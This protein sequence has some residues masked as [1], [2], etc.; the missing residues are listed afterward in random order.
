MTEYESLRKKIK[1]GDVILFSGKSGFSAGIKWMTKSH[2][3]HVGMAIRLPDWDTVLLWESTTLNDI[4]DVESGL[5]KKGVQ[6]V[7]LS[8]RIANYRG[9]VA[10]RHLLDVEFTIAMIASLK[11]LRTEL[12][13]RPYEQDKVELVKSVYEGPWGTNQEDL[14]SLF[15]SELVAEAYQRLGLL[16]LEVPS[17]EYT[18]KDFSKAGRIKLLKGK[19][20]DEV[21]LKNIV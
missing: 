20:G 17:N 14:S 18:P 21:V 16:P 13:N 19:L 3:S 1:T 8:L 6:L 9:D 15:C 4:Q 10:V 5:E 7:P 2:W 11:E 12:K